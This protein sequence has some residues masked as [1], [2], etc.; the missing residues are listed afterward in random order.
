M[1]PHCPARVPAEQAIP[2]SEAPGYLS[3]VADSGFLK[4]APRDLVLTAGTVL[5]ADRVPSIQHIACEGRCFVFSACQFLRQIDNSQVLIRGV[6]C[7]VSPIGKLLA[8]PAVGEETILS[9]EI[10]PAEIVPGKFDLDV[11]GHYA[12]PDVFQ[13]RVNESPQR[14]VSLEVSEAA[15][16]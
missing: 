4:D 13:L 1:R 16:K 15:V 11:T 2:P 7:I 12:R 10:D 8:G 9:A 5:V 3:L 14:P 6:S